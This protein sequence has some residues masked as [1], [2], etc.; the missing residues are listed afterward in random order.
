[1]L[2][3]LLGVRLYRRNQI[4]SLLP[5]QSTVDFVGVCSNYKCSLTDVWGAMDGLK[6]LLESASQEKTQNCFYNGWTHDH[7]DQKLT[8]LYLVVACHAQHYYMY[9][10]EH[11]H[12]LRPLLLLL[13]HLLVCHRPHPPHHWDY[14]VRQ[15]FASTLAGGVEDGSTC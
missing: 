3:S 5:P 10:H 2:Y 11:Y 12:D 9:S 4:D 8:P 1:M 14:T 6:L 15:V 13:V 7:L